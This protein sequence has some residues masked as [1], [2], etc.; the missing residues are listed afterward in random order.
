MLD[1]DRC[2]MVTGAR[3]MATGLGCHQL[4]FEDLSVNSQEKVS[5]LSALLSG[6]RNV[7]SSCAHATVMSGRSSVI[8]GRRK[9]GEAD[10]GSLMLI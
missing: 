6:W 5:M 1:D 10:T 9:E 8:C 2:Y 3:R 7:E 4:T